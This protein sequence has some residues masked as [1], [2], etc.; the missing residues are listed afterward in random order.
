MHCRRL[1]STPAAAMLSVACARTDEDSRSREEQQ[2]RLAH[3][4]WYGRYTGVVVREGQQ[5]RLAHST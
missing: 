5:N 3:S 1:A 2:N 4:T